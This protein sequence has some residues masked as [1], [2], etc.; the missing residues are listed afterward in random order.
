[1]KPKPNKPVTPAEAREKLAKAVNDLMAGVES[2]TLSLQIERTKNVYPLRLTEAQRDTLLQHTQISGKLKKK[3]EEA[4]A[5]PQVINVTG[6]E[7]DQLNDEIG[8]ASPHAKSPHKKRLVAMLHRVAKLFVYGIFEKDTPKP[9]PL[10]TVLYQFKITLLDVQPAIWRRIQVDDCSLDKLHEHIQTA[11]GWLNCHLHRFEIDGERYSDLDPDGDD[12]GMDFKDETKVLLRSV[13]PKSGRRT[14]W[15]YAYDFGDG[16][17]HEILFE[18]FPPVDP[19]KKYPLCVEGERA[20][21]PEDCGGPF[22]YVDFLAAI[23]DPDHEE[24][25]ITLEWVGGEFKPEKFSAKAATRAMREGL[26]GMG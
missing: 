21:P 25:E 19:K 13:L 5:G 16:W 15:M 7:L 23:Q 26:P 14:Q 3:I 6:K 10:P 4:G 1:M 17:K 11:M 12:Y 18:G 9:H 22:G 24:H 2:K 8:A 20:C